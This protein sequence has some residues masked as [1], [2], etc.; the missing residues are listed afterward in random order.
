MYSHFSETLSGVSTIRAYSVIDQFIDRNDH[1]VDHNNSSFLASAIAN[2]WLSIRLESIANLIVL[3]SAIFSV[4]YREKLD[5][6]TVGLV[7]T[8]ALSTT[9]NLSFLVRSTTD[10]E[11]K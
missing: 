9:Q 7:I 10:I 8:Y 2:R 6:S 11:T 3:F 1:N 4:V 5:A